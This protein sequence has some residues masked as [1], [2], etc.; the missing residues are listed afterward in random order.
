MT[1]ALS[2]TELKVMSVVW[3]RDGLVSA[4]DIS[5]QI[6]SAHGYTR[7]AIY[8]LIH[9]LVDK[10]ALVKEDPGFMC[11]AT[12]SKDDVRLDQTRSLIDRLFDGSADDLV[13]SLVANEDISDETIERL[14][15]LID[16]N[17]S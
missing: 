8:T 14:R 11:R 7:G 16:K 10:G 5:S 4:K 17:G 12:V 1:V 2:D 6:Q 9:R 3:Q 15:R 13:V